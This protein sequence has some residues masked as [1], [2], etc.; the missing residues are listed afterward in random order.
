MGRVGVGGTHTQT[1]TPH[2]HR[3]ERDAVSVSSDVWDVSPNG[4]G[5]ALQTR[6]REARSHARP[7]SEIH[8]P[9]TILSAG[10]TILASNSSARHCKHQDEVHL[11]WCL[12]SAC[13]CVPQQQCHLASA[14]AQSGGRSDQGVGDGDR[15]QHFRPALMVLATALP[16]R[17]VQRL[18]LSEHSFTC[19]ADVRRSFKPC[20][21]AILYLGSNSNS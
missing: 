4:W 17:T 8:V 3:D 15:L 2:S 12:M 21:Q 18:E 14:S 6:Y 11:R 19:H 13:T 5:G 10:S 7:L 16:A 9:C 20:S 1:H